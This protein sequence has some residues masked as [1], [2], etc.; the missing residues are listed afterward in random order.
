MWTISQWRWSCYR[1]IKYR[2]VLHN[3]LFICSV[4]LFVYCICLFFI[5]GCICLCFVYLSF[6]VLLIIF[7]RVILALEMVMRSCFLV[8][9]FHLFIS[10]VF[11]L[12][13]G[14]LIII[15]LLIISKRWS[16]LLRWWWGLGQMFITLSALHASNV[17]TGDG[18]GDGEEIL[19]FEAHLYN[20][21]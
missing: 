14:L 13:A 5:V 16:R 12:L 6:I 10:C 11:C 3:C 7:K 17:D 8:C 2:G 21:S 20:F 15:L 19:P 9:L 4:Y 1:R 18:D